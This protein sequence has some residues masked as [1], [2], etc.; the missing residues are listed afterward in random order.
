MERAAR[1]YV[2][3]I[4]E[5]WAFG[6]EGTLFESFETLELAIAR[7]KEFSKHHP[8]TEI[9]IVDANGKERAA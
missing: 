3:Q 9:V 5:R 4:G 6:R 7:A 1:L 2:Q 8:E